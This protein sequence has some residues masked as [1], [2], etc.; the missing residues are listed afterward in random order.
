MTNSLP[1]GTL[2]G[3]VI[4]FV[5][6]V[7]TGICLWSRFYL[8]LVVL[9]IALTHIPEMELISTLCMYDSLIIMVLIRLMIHLSS[10]LPSGVLIL[11]APERIRTS[12]SDMPLQ[13]SQV[14]NMSEYR[15]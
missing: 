1:F 6:M 5:S 13:P 4:H 12:K 11:S 14:F 8:T 2:L 3:R 7:L 9:F 10:L 15:L